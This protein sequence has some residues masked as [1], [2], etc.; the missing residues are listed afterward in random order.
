MTEEKG[1]PGF[2]YKRENVD[3]L[4]LFESVILFEVCRNLVTLETINPITV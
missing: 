3:W 2:Y 1:L 4:R